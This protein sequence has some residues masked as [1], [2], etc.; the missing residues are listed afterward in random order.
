MKY[1]FPYKIQ[2]FPFSFFTILYF[3]IGANFIIKKSLYFCE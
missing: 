2:F 3:M 1:V